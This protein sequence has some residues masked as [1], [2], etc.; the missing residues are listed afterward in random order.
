MVRTITAIYENGVLRP[1]EPLNLEERQ[2]VRLQVI[3]TVSDY[4][5][6]VAAYERFMALTPESDEPLPPWSEIKEMFM[7]RFDDETT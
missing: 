7:N 5:E 4:A 3:E 1:Q 2:V 6:R